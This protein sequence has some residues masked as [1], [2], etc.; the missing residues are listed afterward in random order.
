VRVRVKRAAAAAAVVV[1]E[2]DGRRAEKRSWRSDTQTRVA[3]R[4]SRRWTDGGGGGGDHFTGGDDSYTIHQRTHARALSFR[5]DGSPRRYARANR[6][7]GAAV[8][9]CPPASPTPSSPPAHRPPAR[10]RIRRRLCARFAHF[11]RR[12]RYAGDPRRKLSTR[13]GRI[14]DPPT[15]IIISI[16]G[17]RYTRVCVCVCVCTYNLYNTYTAIGCKR[18]FFIFI[19]IVIVSYCYIIKINTR[20]NIITTRKRILRVFTYFY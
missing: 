12:R 17:M 9:E 6:N 2:R 11:R 13:D 3:R 20:Y 7:G 10:S 19:V 4:R 8:S 15:R 16:P 14:P 1:C 18:N 5:R